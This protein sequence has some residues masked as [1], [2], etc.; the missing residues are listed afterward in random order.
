MACTIAAA[1]CEDNLISGSQSEEC[2]TMYKDFSLIVNARYPEDNSWRFPSAVQYYSH[3]IDSLRNASVVDRNGRYVANLKLC[4]S[5]DVVTVVASEKDIIGHSRSE[6]LL[7]DVVRAEQSGSYNEEAVF[8]S[9]AAVDGGTISLDNIVSFLKVEVK[10][11]ETRRLVLRTMDNGV[12]HYNGLVLLDLNSGRFK[13]LD[14]QGTTISVNVNGKGSYYFSLIP[15]T[16]SSGFVI[17]SY[18]QNGTLQYSFTYNRSVD[19]ERGDIFDFG[20]VDAEE[21]DRYEVNSGLQLT[22]LPDRIWFKTPYSP[23]VTL[24]GKNYYAVLESLD[25][26]MAVEDMTIVP[27]NIGTHRIKASIQYEEHLWYYREFDLDVYDKADFYMMI[28]AK[29]DVNTT[30]GNSQVVLYYSGL[31]PVTI[32]FGIK[33]SAK[34][35]IGSLKSQWLY[36]I[37]VITLSPG[38]TLVLADYQALYSWVKSNLSATLSLDVYL[39]CDNDYMI[40][41]FDTQNIRENLKKSTTK[42]IEFRYNGVKQW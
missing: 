18:D 19:L 7:G 9:V 42:K 32:Q 2:G 40:T 37:R 33:G 36:S 15:M 24:D 3:G 28:K 11:A 39:T 41:S 17:D 38:E 10:R 8:M 22:N 34:P 27:N 13:Q 30:Y 14:E 5:D 31:Q 25:G 29:D 20:V 35:L 26:T 16:Y 23:S 4:G 6:L 1:S 12:L 21:E